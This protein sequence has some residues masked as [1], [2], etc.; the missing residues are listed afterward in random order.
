MKQN[1]L[2]VLLLLLIVSLFSNSYSTARKLAITNKQGEAGVN[3]NKIS[4]RDFYLQKETVNSFDKVTEA[5]E[6]PNKDEECLRR[7]LLEAHL[8][9]IYTQHH[10]P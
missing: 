10:K 1:F 8:D 7:V 6:C 9:Y 2:P 3:L 4:N 5:E